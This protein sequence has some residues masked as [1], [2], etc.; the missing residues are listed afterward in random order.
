MRLDRYAVQPVRLDIILTNLDAIR[1]FQGNAGFKIVSYDI[2]VEF[3]VQRIG[4]HQS[5]AVAV[6]KVRLHHR[7]AFPHPQAFF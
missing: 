3:S 6:D 5:V 2:A 1:A 7:D 4:H